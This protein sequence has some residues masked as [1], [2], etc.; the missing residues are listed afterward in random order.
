MKAV[1][2][3]FVAMA[4]CVATAGESF[5]NGMIE[6]VADPLD[7]SKLE[8]LLWDGAKTK[9]APQIKYGHR[10]Y[11]PVALDPAVVRGV[12]WPTRQSDC[13]STRGLFDRMLELG[14]GRNCRG[15]CSIT[16]VLNLQH[17]VS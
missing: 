8:L 14:E 3:R 9:I 1:S 11:E 15:A 6:L 5:P 13:G 4:K 16:G 10:T 12:R 2:T 7:P 17:L